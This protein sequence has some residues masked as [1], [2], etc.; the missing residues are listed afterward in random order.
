MKKRMISNTAHRVELV[1]I[2]S[3]VEADVIAEVVVGLFG[4]IN[5]GS[6]SLALAPISSQMLTAETFKRTS[7]VQLGTVTIPTVSVRF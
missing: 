3:E 2:D 1:E 6:M 5:M 4:F 7:R